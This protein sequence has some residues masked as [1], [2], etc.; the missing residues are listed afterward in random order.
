MEGADDPYVLPLVALRF[1]RQVRNGPTPS[2][3]FR[4]KCPLT[5]LSDSYVTLSVRV[6]FKFLVYFI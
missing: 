4:V 6:S 2:L 1:I 3:S 5:V